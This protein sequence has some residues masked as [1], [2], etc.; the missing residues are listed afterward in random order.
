MKLLLVLI[1]SP[2]LTYSQTGVFH[3][4]NEKITY[5]EVVPSGLLS[6]SLLR[7]THKSFSLLATS[8]NN[9]V[10]YDENKL[11]DYIK[12]KDS[13]S[14][15]GNI[16]FMVQQ[17]FG[18]AAYEATLAIEVKDNRYRYTI[19][20]ITLLYQSTIG[21]V[22][23]PLEQ[24]DTPRQTNFMKKTDKTIKELIGNIKDNMSKHL[25]DF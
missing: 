22:N 10:N 1:A 7:N 21:K 11:K 8:F 9:S 14:V 25:P 16:R 17:A 6:S 13:S 15:V 2:L 20:N 12:H 23:S 18:S 3:Y 19:D 4:S 24:W 5:S